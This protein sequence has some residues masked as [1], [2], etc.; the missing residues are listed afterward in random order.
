[1]F[2][3]LLALAVAETTAIKH[4][5][6]IDESKLEFKSLRHDARVT[7]L[8]ICEARVLHRA[9]KALLAD[10]GR[11]LGALNA[12]ILGDEKELDA[13]IVKKDIDPTAPSAIKA[14]EDVTRRRKIYRDLSVLRDKAVAE[15]EDTLI[16]AVNE[17][18]LRR[19]AIIKGVE[20]LRPW[21]HSE[22]E[23]S[24]RAVIKAAKIAEIMARE[25]ADKDAAKESQETLD[26]FL[27]GNQVAEYIEM[28][29]AN[30]EKV[31]LSLLAEHEAAIKKEAFVARMKAAK[32]AKQAK[33]EAEEA[34]FQRLLEEEAEAKLAEENKVKVAFFLSMAEKADNL[35][36]VKVYVMAAHELD[37]SVNSMVLVNAAAARLAAAVIVETKKANKAVEACHVKPLKLHAKERRELARVG[38]RGKDWSGVAMEA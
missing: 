15:N 16:V 12:K 26:L 24:R 31:M 30:L 10:H 17:M 3:D 8:A 6:W 22:E 20:D 28:I 35:D 2:Q 25:E 27:F 7:A 34:E 37:A 11:K 33:K 36:D 23:S 19:D 32:V 1:M 9:R 29:C 5:V 13:R 18:R 14:R 21:L 38:V 4:Q